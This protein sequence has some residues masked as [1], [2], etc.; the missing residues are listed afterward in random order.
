MLDVPYDW[1]QIVNIFYSLEILGHGIGA[2]LCFFYIF[3]RNYIFVT[4]MP[5]IINS[6]LT[7]PSLTTSHVLTTDETLTDGS[8]ILSYC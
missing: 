3:E 6:Q 2:Q 8:Y 4:D 5:T 7:S 1:I